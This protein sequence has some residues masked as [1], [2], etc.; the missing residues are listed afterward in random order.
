MK[1]IK[2]VTGL[3]VAVMAAFG[4][5]TLLPSCGEASSTANKLIILHTNDTH[6]QIDPTGDNLG[7]LLRRAAAIDSVRNAC[8]NVLY[9][10]A[11]DDV[12]GTL[13]FYLYGGRVEQEA[14]NLMGLDEG[15]LGNHE[16]DNGIDSLARILALR[17][18]K[19]ITS[20]Y[21]TE[22]TPLDT[23]FIPYSV[24]E[25]KGKKIGFMGINLDPEGIIAEDCY[26]GLGFQPIVATAN[27]TA[28]KLRD[29]EGCDAV[30]A[31]THIGYNPAGLTGDSILALNSRGIDV[32]IGGHSHDL[33]DPNTPQ[34][35]RRSRMT[36]LDGLEV[37]VTQAGKKGMKLGKIEINLDSL[38]KG[39]RP[40][41]ELID[42]DSRFDGKAS[43]EM[44][45]LRDK[46]YPGVDSLMHLWIGST[47]HELDDSSDE[48]LNFFA[49]YV[50]DRS[51]EFAAN[52][53]F[54]V[55]NKGGLR[56]SIPAGNFSKGHII[57]MVPFRNYITVLD[58]K[59]SDLIEIFKVMASTEGNGVSGNVRA[60]Y[61][62]E[63]GGFELA[64]LPTINGKPISAS[65][66]YR[67]ATIDYLAKGGDYMKNFRNGTKVADSG[68]W[69][70]DDLIEYFTNGKGKNKILTGSTESRWTLVNN[71]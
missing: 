45:A 48:L 37:L 62:P 9:V 30:I 25:V 66:T 57:N 17:D 29:E 47:E 7:G 28:A 71:H 65:R 21:V 13:Y 16:F 12:Q 39:G 33:I 52:V 23:L 41:Y 60:A 40:R 44:V 18:R 3:S 14:F 54:S 51:R 31:L 19:L 24:R 22:G 50:L 59:G 32:I 15:I 27:A 34:G 36:N 11:G 55:V 26:A 8:E 56:A 53:D 38:G 2:A 1:F 68:S 10:D 46:Y 35:A 69:I 70:Y 43:A 20:N 49:D 4:A 6:S 58:V 42:I 61:C 5:I 67:V 64:G 63:D